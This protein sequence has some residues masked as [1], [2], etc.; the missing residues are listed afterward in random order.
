MTQIF[1]WFQAEQAGAELYSKIYMKTQG[2]AASAAAYKQ[3]QCVYICVCARVCAYQCKH[4]ICQLQ[5]AAKE[6]TCIPVRNADDRVMYSMQY[7]LATNSDTQPN[8]VAHTVKPAM[9]GN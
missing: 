1:Y 5:V 8:I 9:R 7:V 2:S 6:Q 4:D 3:C